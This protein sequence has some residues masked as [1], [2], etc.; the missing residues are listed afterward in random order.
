MIVVESSLDEF[1]T[2]EVVGSTVNYVGK[3]D[4]HNPCFDDLGTATSFD[5]FEKHFEATQIMFQQPPGL[6][7]Y[8]TIED[9]R[10]N[11]DGD[12][13]VFI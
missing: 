9:I 5:E 2:L 11:T 6:T 1:F 12:P 7:E 13:Y 8:L 10:A 3:G 4:Y